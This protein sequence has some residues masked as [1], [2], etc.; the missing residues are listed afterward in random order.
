MIAEQRRQYVVDLS[1]RTGISI[2]HKRMEAHPLPERPD[3][4]ARIIRQSTVPLTLGTR[5]GPYEITA[6]IG[7][8]GMG[9]VWRARDTKLRRDVA[10]KILP[11]SVANDPERLSRFHREAEFLASLNH[12]NIAHIHGLEESGDVTALVMELVEGEDLAQRIAHGAIPLNDALPIARQIAEAL[13][14][15]H[16]HDIIHRDL[17]PANI[18]VRPDGIVKVLD[19]GLAKALERPTHTAAGAESDTRSVDV[20][21]AGYILGTPAYMSPEQA[22]GGLVDE[23]SDIWA[24]GAVLFEMLTGRRAFEASSVAETLGAVMTRQL[25]FRS[26]EPPAR[27]LVEWC[28]ERD[29]RKRLRVV[30]DGVRMIDARGGAFARRRGAADAQAGVRSSPPAAPGRRTSR[31]RR[32]PA[33]EIVHAYIVPPPGATLHNGGPS[34]VLALSPNGRDIAFIAESDGIRRVWIRPLDAP[35]AR[36]LD[37]TE[38]ADAVFWAP[39]SV[40]LG[41]LT[42]GT[43]R[44]VDIASGVA[45]DIARIGGMRGISWG[46]QRTILVGTL[47]QGIVAVPAN[48]GTPVSVTRPRVGDEYHYYPHFLPDGDRFFYSTP[49][50]VFVSTLTPG[51]TAA[52]RVLDDFVNLQY[53]PGAEGSH[54]YVLFPRTGTLY[55][56]RFDPDRLVLEGSMIAVASEVGAR[57][58][59]AHSQFSASHNGRLVMLSP[60]LAEVTRVSRTGQSVGSL[61]A[62]GPFATMTP[63]PD[64]RK[65]AVLYLEPYS[66][67]SGVR[68]LDLDRGTLTPI[69]GGGIFPHHAWSPDGTQL[70]YDSLRESTPKLY[71]AN[72]NGGVSVEL[73]ASSPL[74]KLPWH[75]TEWGL[76]YGEGPTGTRHDL[77]LLPSDSGTPRT[78]V[79]NGHHAYGAQVSP[80]GAWI[81][82]VTDETGTDQ[83]YLQRFPESIGERMPVSTTGGTMPVWRDDGL[84]LFYSSEVGRL[85]AVRVR[86]EGASVELGQPQALFD[87][88]AT[89][90]YRGARAWWPCAGGQEFLVLRNAISRA[91]Q[92]IRL[93]LNWP[94]L[95]EQRDQ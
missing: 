74:V 60:P 80:D 40:S 68:V 42:S 51:Q 71:R 26:I 47:L 44:C 18:R 88:G 46:A 45:R 1:R 49:S 64:G 53:V 58:G 54:G 7:V 84:E 12:P 78:L 19:F 75:W 32:P 72:A 93:T 91:S 87:L 69:S 38:G 79:A 28:L 11:D 41:L 43:I 29:P 21:R 76:V 23:R 25:D 50:G 62:A 17:K 20:T 31:S 6:Q 95:I 92:N 9:E 4:S 83:V 24:F 37:G 34:P 14:A 61:A 77:K 63:S 36:P 5:V 81:A 94:E 82:F 2:S 86:A 67:L 39:D 16:E 59:Q 8:G 35:A 27:Q 52:V 66:E 90:W 48:G 65:A 13:D 22:Q 56:Q 10:I 33:L 15:A 73:L 85:M 55:A 70:V 3:G 89:I 57:S 30:R